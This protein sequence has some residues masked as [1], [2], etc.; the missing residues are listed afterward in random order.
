MTTKVKAQETI[1]EA[2][3]LRRA[4]E[5]AFLA[6][7]HTELDVVR[8]WC[9]LAEREDGE[10]RTHHIQQAEKAFEW[11]LQIGRRIEPSPQDRRDI[12]EALQSIRQLS[13]RDFR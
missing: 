4:A 8:T 9:L 13:G 6:S 3:E 10:K 1:V 12:E 2:A 5:E 7:M 11:A